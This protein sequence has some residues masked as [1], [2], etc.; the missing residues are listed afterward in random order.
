ML[1][2]TLGAASVGDHPEGIW[3]EL[4]TEELGVKVVWLA[5]V[6]GTVHCFV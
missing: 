4:Y 3:Y 1:C 2:D 5:D 6:D